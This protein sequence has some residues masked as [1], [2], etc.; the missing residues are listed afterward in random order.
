M[1]S[2]KYNCVRFWGLFSCGIIS[3]LFPQLLLNKMKSLKK[4]HFATFLCNLKRTTKSKQGEK[5]DIRMY[6]QF[7]DIV[8]IICT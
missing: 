8:T 2:F 3:F 4:N 1:N 5:H 7:F 6:I